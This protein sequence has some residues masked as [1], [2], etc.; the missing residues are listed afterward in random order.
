M[1]TYVTIK[2]R[3]RFEIPKIKGSRFIGTVQPVTGTDTAEQFINEIRREFHNATH[4][5]WAYRLGSVEEFRYNDDGEPSGTAGKP[6]LQS[7]EA[8]D[9]RYTAVVV[10][11]FYGGTKLGTG[12]LIR[13]YHECAEQTLAHA[14]K[15]VRV[16]FARLKISHDFDQI[17]PVQHAIARFGAVIEQTEYG[18]AVTVQV[19][20]EE[21]KAELFR[22][23]LIETTANKVYCE[24]LGTIY[25]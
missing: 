4:N 14:E 13:A 20:L 11:R 1:S 24:H 17:N 18:A 22:Q 10:T 12:G 23:F 5:C 15:V 8:M 6:I 19:A 21:E 16:L 9:L 7:I 3:D 2:H 25:Q